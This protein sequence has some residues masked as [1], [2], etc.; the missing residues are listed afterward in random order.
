MRCLDEV[1]PRKAFFRKGT[2]EEKKIACFTMDD[3]VKYAELVPDEILLQYR[4]NRQYINRVL[5]SNEIHREEFTGCKMAFSRVDK[6]IYAV[7][8]LI[9]WT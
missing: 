3:M 1:Q 7:N 5:S 8:P 9:K 4:K 6:G 2:H